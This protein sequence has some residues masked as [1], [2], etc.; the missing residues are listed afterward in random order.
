[1]YQSEAAILLSSGNPAEKWNIQASNQD[2]TT[3]IV[4]TVGGSHKKKI[5]NM[6]D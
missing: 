4:A 6:R 3:T 2:H 1:M 5:E